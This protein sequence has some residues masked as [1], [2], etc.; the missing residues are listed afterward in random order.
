[1]MTA[2]AVEEHRPIRDDGVQVVTRGQAS[3]S[4]VVEVLSHERSS[5]RDAG[6]CLGQDLLYFADAL[7]L[8]DG[9]PGDERGVA[10]RMQVRIDEARDDHRSVVADGR[11]RAQLIAPGHRHDPTVLDHDRVS[12]SGRTQDRVG[13]D[14]G[15]RHTR[16]SGKCVATIR[17]RLSW[18]RPLL[19]TRTG[20][21]KTY[22]RSRWSVTRPPASSR[23]RT[24]AAMS[25]GARENS[26]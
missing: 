24:P 15:G 5:G 18:I 13:D 23:I 10:E 6:G 20:E 22:G 8:T 14:D 4:G 16:W 2:I 21:P 25:H 12:R 11:G 26:Q 7:G 3:Q 1:H 9:H 17:A 19:A